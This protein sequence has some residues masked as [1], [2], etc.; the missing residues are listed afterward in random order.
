MEQTLLLSSSYEPI[1]IVSWQRAFGM[2]VR[3]KVEV[4]EEYERIVR[5]AR[6]VYKM[7][8]V[9]R[10]LGPFNRYK[11]NLKFSKQHVF[12]RDHWKCQYCGAKPG[13]SRLTYDHVVP[14][15]RGGSTCW[16][17]IVTAC[18]DCNSIKGDRTPEEARMYPKIEPIQ[19]R[20]LP[21]FLFSVSDN[22]PDEWKAYCYFLKR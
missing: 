6:A 14:K 20:A 16:E 21:T 17:N 18:A 5:S 2:I 3:G 9:I 15:S 10:L 8:A 19:P 22:A 12:A 11:R 4:V 1:R 7:P 13:A